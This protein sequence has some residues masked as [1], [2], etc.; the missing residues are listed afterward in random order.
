MAANDHDL[1]AQAP[2]PLRHWNGL[3]EDERLALRE[4]FG[5]YQDDLPAT[6][7][8]AEKIARFRRWLTARGVDY[9]ETP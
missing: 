4:A 5:R 6:C 3:G 9:D 1:D 7:D 2:R 8:M